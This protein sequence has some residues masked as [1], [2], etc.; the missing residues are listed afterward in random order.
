MG[1]V[2]DLFNSVLG[3]SGGTKDT[4]TQVQYLPQQIQDINN[5]LAYKEGTVRPGFTDVM[6]QIQGSFN[7]SMPGVY[8]QAQNLVG[9][10]GQAQSALG[11]T[12]ESALRTGIS[13]LQNLF[14]PDYEANQVKSA[15]VPAQAM[16]NQNLANQAANFGGM[17]Q[18]GS[19]RQALAQNQLAGQTQAAEMQT[20]ANIQQQIAQ[21]RQ[22][23]ANS[24]AQLGQ[25]GLS[26]AL[27]AAKLGVE[28]SMVPQQLTGQ[29]AQQMYS[30]PG[31]IYQ[32]QYPGTNSTQQS[33]QTGMGLGGLV[34]KVGSTLFG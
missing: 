18:L 19:A 15:L 32:P 10:A 6:N 13:G 12:G 11:S 24:L 20:A 31:A 1:A 5:T 16:Y 28:G 27:G 23:A 34:G 17:G 9:T 14:T 8:N 33:Q 7:N 3:S 30:L 26:Q 21:Q 29:Y 2:G 25:G 22:N 4:S